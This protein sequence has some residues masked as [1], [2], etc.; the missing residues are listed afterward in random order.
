MA[1]FQDKLDN[2]GK[3]IA[4]QIPMEGPFFYLPKVYNKKGKVKK[5]ET[6]STIFSWR[7][8]HLKKFRWIQPP[9]PY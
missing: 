7:N 6:S 5:S 9:P 4:Y 3:F 1:T 8:G 2:S